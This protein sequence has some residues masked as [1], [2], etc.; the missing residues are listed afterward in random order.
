MLYKTRSNQAWK[1]CIIVWTHP[2][3]NEFNRCTD[4]SGNGNYTIGEHEIM[5]FV[6]TM[7]QSPNDTTKATISWTETYFR[8]QNNN[9]EHE[10]RRTIDY[11]LEAPLNTKYPSTP[12]YWAP[13]ANV[14]VLY[15]ATTIIPGKEHHLDSGLYLDDTWQIGAGLVEYNDRMRRG[16]E[17][18]G[19]WDKIK[20][21]K[22]TYVTFIYGNLKDIIPE[23]H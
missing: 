23:I 13:S 11:L 21:S 15:D 12:F 20:H 16:G 7:K 17:H 10:I 14:G 2:D 9:T 3:F 8:G 22:N 1:C 5:P 4:A 18:A 6:G 19:Q